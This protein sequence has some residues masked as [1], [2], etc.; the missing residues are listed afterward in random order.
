MMS[1]KSR[2]ILV[3]SRTTPELKSTSPRFENS[4]RFLSSSSVLSSFLQCFSV[5]RVPASLF[6]QQHLYSLSVAGVFNI[7]TLQFVLLVR[8]KASAHKL[9]EHGHRLVDYG[10]RLVEFAHP[11]VEFA[12]QLVEYTQWLA[13]LARDGP[14]LPPSRAFQLYV[15]PMQKYNTKA[16][17][18]S[19]ADAWPNFVPTWTFRK[20]KTRSTPLIS[21]LAEVSMDSLAGKEP[22]VCFY[23]LTKWQ[24]EQVTKTLQADRSVIY[25]EYTEQHIYYDLSVVIRVGKLV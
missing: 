13:Q 5:V 3:R 1:A 10:H 16:F 11:L 7:S 9:L 2:Q 19:V 23:N 12:H 18:A 4:R 14:R 22:E 25:A 21:R 6:K 17:I 20:E 24:P 8:C 15:R